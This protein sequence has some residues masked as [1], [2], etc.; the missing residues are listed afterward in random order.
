MQRTNENQTLF[1]E[2][3]E[4][5]NK[6]IRLEKT[7][8]VP[9]A[10]FFASWVQRSQGSSYRDIYYD[11]EAAGKA[12][13][14]FYSRHP[15]LDCCYGARFTSGRANEIAQSQMIDWPGRPGTKVADTSSHQVIERE[16]MTQEEYPEMLGDFT[17]F[18]LR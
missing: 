11:H 14:E 2:R 1:N 7:D 8:R 16:F 13:V 15:M 4:R 5:V 12:A 17:G 9:L 18:M 6:A 10:P 3:L